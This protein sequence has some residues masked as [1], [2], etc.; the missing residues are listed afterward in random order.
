MTD[1]F[2]SEILAVVMQQILDEPVLPTLFMRTVSRSF[3]RLLRVT[4][5]THA[6]QGDPSCQNVQIADRLRF[7]DATITVGHKKDMDNPLALGGFHPMCPD[8]RPCKLSC[9]VAASERAATGASGEA[10]K[11]ARPTT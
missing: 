8:R 6:T 7:H 4:T 9:I 5:L 10:T 11:F 3:A 2:R 1:V